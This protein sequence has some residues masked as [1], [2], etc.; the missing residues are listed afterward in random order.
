MTRLRPEL[1][2]PRGIAVLGASG[3]PERLGHRPLKYLAATGF[4][5]AVYPVNPRRERIGDLRCY[6]DLASVPDPVDLA[7]ISLAADQVPGALNACAA[8]GVGMAVILSADLPPDL[9]P[10]EGLLVMGPNSMGFLDAHAPV[11]ATWNS[12][13]D[14][15]TV[16]AGS[17][18]LIAQSGGLGGAVLNR[19]LDRGIG[20][21]QAFFSGEERF[22]DTCDLLELLL[23][24]AATGLIV[25]LVEG[26]RRPTRF[27]ELARRAREREVPLIA[28]KLA[29][30]PRSAVAALAHTGMLAGRRRVQQAAFRQVGIVEAETLDV[31]VDLAVVFAQTPAKPTPFGGRLAVFTTSGGAAILAQ[32]VCDSLGLELPPPSAETVEALRPLLHPWTPIAN[33]LDVGAGLP[34]GDLLRALATLAAD[35]RIDVVVSINTMI[36]GRAKLAERARGLLDL[37]AELPKP[38]LTCWLGGSLS[39]EALTILRDAGRPHFLSVEACLGALRAAREYHRRRSLW[40][41]P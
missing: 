22:L 12:T 1:L 4:A 30:S 18:G 8:R 9:R 35:P 27:L 33:P 17:V 13:L 32:D 21:S 23:D 2:R 28:F 7:L 26:L 34:E 25:L 38:L 40:I 16:R 36:G 15:G 20:I 19:L 31:V 39:E 41:S 24:D 6:P 37:A 14:L 11:A 29:R 5:G 10:P 3:D